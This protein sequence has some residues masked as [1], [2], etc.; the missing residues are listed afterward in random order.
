MNLRRDIQG[1]FAYPTLVIFCEG[2]KGLD[3]SHPRLWWSQFP[4]APRCSHVLQGQPLSLI[5]FILYLTVW[6]VEPIVIHQ[7]SW[8]DLSL[9]LSLSLVHTL[10]THNS[11]HVPVT[12]TA[13]HRHKPY[14]LFRLL[15][16][17]L[18][19]LN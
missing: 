1:M 3:R 16:L 17:L 8:L 4:F 11:V 6:G 12:Q 2:S 19:H 15:L 7:T 13:C 18:R 10:R 14:L 9:Y 5:H